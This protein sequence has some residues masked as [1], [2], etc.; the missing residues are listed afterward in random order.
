MVYSIRPMPNEIAYFL[1]NLE[2][3]GRKLWKF[4]NF[5]ENLVPKF[6]CKLRNLNLQS[7]Q[8][9]REHRGPRERILNST[10]M[11]SISFQTM[12]NK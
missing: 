9:Y 4:S 3:N 11:A 7:F 1:R 8:H 12:K 5:C 10:N 6:G 2:P